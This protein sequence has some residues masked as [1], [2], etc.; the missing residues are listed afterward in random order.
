MKNERRTRYS[1]LLVEA[2]V[3]LLLTIVLLDL[4]GVTP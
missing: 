2:S 1:E 3:A 4:I